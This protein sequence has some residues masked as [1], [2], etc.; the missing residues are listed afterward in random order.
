MALQLSVCILNYA[1]FLYT[2]MS[3]YQRSGLDAGERTIFV[4]ATST[5]TVSVVNESRAL[6]MC[7]RMQLRLLI[8]LVS[9]Q[10][11]NAIILINVSQ[12]NQNF[13]AGTITFQFNISEDFPTQCSINGGVFVDC[14][15]TLCLRFYLCVCMHVCSYVHRDVYKCINLL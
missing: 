15:Y 5:E 13:E 11:L 1:F 2:G 7:Q 10:M 4:R 3:G 6:S 14:E 8:L 12:A 9:I